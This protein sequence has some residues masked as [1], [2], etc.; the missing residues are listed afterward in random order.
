[1]KILRDL[2][3]IAGVIDTGNKLFTGVNDTGDI[4]T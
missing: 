2:V 1:M 3:S 4:T